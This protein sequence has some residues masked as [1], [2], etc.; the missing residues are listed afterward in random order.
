LVK[1]DGYY[2][3]TEILE[4]SELKEL[5]TD[6]T[7]SWVKKNLFRLPVEVPYTPWKRRLLFVPYSILSA[8]Y[9]Y[10][11]LFFVVQFLYN[12]GY[13]YNPQWAFVPA[14]I[15]A[16][17][18]FRSRL[19]SAAR[20][21]YNVYLDKKDLLKARLRWYRTWALGALALCLLFVPFWR[22]TVSGSFVLEPIR[23]SIVRAHLPGTVLEVLTHESG[24]VNAGAA[25]VQLRNLKL[26]SRLAHA[27]SENATA[28]DRATQA[29]LRNADYASLESERERFAQQLRLLRDEATQL[30]LTSDISGVV[31]TPRMQD[32]I[33][34]YILAGT[35]VAEVADMSAMRARIYVAESDLRKVQEGS[36]ASIH[37]N[38]MLSSLEGAAIAISPATVDIPEGVMEKEQYVGLHTPHYY[39]V[40]IDVPNRASS[41]KI[42]MTGEAKV[43]VRRRSV[44]GMLE[45]NVGN[46]VSRKIW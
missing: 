1:L 27:E 10:V 45:E 22:E 23:K 12:V 46:F 11:L 15:L 38:G 39:V 34:T 5:S 29:R 18:V 36:R 35:E 14:V 19:R 6:F 26:E 7:T 31:V 43:F 17:L 21:S 33:G 20:F 44:A 24:T 28:T 42:G 16:W 25:I 9:G 40:D 4:I 32:L 30:T 3:F 13:R 2:I 37:V 8:A 41:L